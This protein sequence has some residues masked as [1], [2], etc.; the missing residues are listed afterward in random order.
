MNKCCK[1]EVLKNV[2]FKRIIFFISAGQ[3]NTFA[4][5][6]VQLVLQNLSKQKKAV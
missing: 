4:N 1:L 6:I 2:H 3:F 5:T